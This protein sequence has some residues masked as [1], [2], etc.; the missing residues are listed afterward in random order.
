[1]SKEE[2]IAAGSRR[3]ALDQDGKKKAPPPVALIV[4]VVVEV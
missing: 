2:K 4:V 1:V 3:W